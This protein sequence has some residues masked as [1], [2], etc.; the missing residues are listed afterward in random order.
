MYNLDVDADRS[1]VMPFVFKSKIVILFLTGSK[2]VNSRYASTAYA[3]LLDIH[4]A[5]SCDHAHQD[6]VAFAVVP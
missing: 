3:G 2:R 5:P 1:R 6:M 4:V